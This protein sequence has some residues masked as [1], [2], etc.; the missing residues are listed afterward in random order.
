MLNY[1]EMFEPFTTDGCTLEMMIL[2][3]QKKTQANDA[4]MA[5]GVAE[6]MNKLAGGEKFDQPPV[7][8]GAVNNIHTTISHYLLSVVADML[9]VTVQSST[10]IIE[11]RQKLLLESQMKQISNFDKE[12]N[13]IL[14]GSVWD[15]IKKFL[16]LPY[17]HWKHEN[18][19]GE[20]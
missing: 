6:V 16:H 5:Q 11:D 9:L 15:K 17:S 10:K 18:I 4:I 19:K 1:E 13:K 12:Y 8:E 20:K 2:W 3:V 7:V 14:N